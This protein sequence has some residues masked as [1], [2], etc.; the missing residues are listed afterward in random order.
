MIAE[1]LAAVERGESVIATLAS[2]KPLGSWKQ[3]QVER[4]TAE[5][6][7]RWAE[8]PAVT[9]FAVVTGAVSSL[10]VLDFDGPRGNRLLGQIGLEPHVRTPRDRH[11]LRIEHPGHRVGTQNSKITKLL[12]QKYPGLDIRADGGYAIEWGSSEHGPYETLRALDELVPISALPEELAFAL[13]LT[14]N[15]CKIPKGQRHKKLHEIASAMRGRGEGADAIL[16]ELRR[17]NKR[18][19]EVPEDDSELRYLAADV[20]KRYGGGAQTLESLLG[21]DKVDVSVLAVRVFG[22]GAR[23]TVEVDVSNGEML[24]WDTVREMLRPANLAAEV[25]ACTGAT[26]NLTI[27]QCMRAVALMR[28]L[29]AIT[30]TM[31]DNEIA[32]EWGLDYLQESELISLNML[33][34]QQRWAAFSRLGGAEGRTVLKHLDGSRFV[35]C[36][37]FR[38]YVREIDPTISQNSVNARMLRVGWSRRATHGRIKATAP[39][40]PAVLGWN[41]WTVPEGWGEDDG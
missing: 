39:G 11:H 38:A 4:A 9:G 22:K 3:A 25:V 15:G 20:E 7:R 32:V 24:T 14:S 1:V 29:A 18:D 10:V 26:P 27:A 6:V 36:G 41:F 40:R 28:E 23:A 16:A 19:C 8:D 21:F 37:W 31:T 34:Q 35:R 12:E 33:D 2:K 13:G 17:V 5:Q 30:K